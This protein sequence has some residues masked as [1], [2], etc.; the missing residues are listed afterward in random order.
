M[1]RSNILK[2]YSINQPIL[3]HS[4]KLSQAG[5]PIRLSSP[6]FKWRHVDLVYKALNFGESDEVAIEVARSFIADSNIHMF[7]EVV[8]S[9]KQT[10]SA[11][12]L[13]TCIL[14]LVLFFLHINYLFSPTF[15]PTYRFAIYSSCYSTKYISTQ[16]AAS[17]RVSRVLVLLLRTWT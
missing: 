7:V 12:V 10:I 15:N 9:I 5:R 8:D 1:L 6:P 3:Y 16:E 2:S 13:E 14:L 17:T 4:K 11:S